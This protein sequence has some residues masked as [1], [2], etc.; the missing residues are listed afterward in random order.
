MKRKQLPLGDLLENYQTLDN[1]WRFR[2]VDKE[3][4]RIEWKAMMDEKYPELKPCPFCEGHPE[5]TPCVRSSSLFYCS[6][7]QI[8]CYECELTFQFGYT[9]EKCI[10]RWNSLSRK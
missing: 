7:A 8:E 5:F 6:G 1:S 4:K 9:S 10:E 2:D 3:T